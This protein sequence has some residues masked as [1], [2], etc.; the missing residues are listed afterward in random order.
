MNNLKNRNFVC[1]DTHGK[2]DM[3]K[4][5]KWY[6]KE[7]SSLTKRDNL[8]ILGDWGAI[9]HYRSDKHKYKKDVELQVKWAKKNFQ[10]IVIPGNHENYD[11]INKLPVIEKWGGKVKV[12]TP[13]SPYTD[14]DY[15]EIYI[16][17]RGEIYTIN[18]DK[19]LAMGGARSQ[20]QAMRIVGEDYWAEE[21]WSMEEENNCLTNLDKHNWEVDYVFAHTC[22]ERIGSF[23]LDGVDAA[24]NQKTYYNYSAKVKDPLSKFFT[25][26]INEGLKFKEWHFGHWHEDL[27]F[28][29]LVNEDGNGAYYVH[30]L[31]EPYEIKD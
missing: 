6:Q 1:G 3:K 20:D 28:N 19:I 21:L 27:V 22:P 8:F 2:I 23:I 30:Y 10:T 12:L 31:K 26:L 14:K 15:G 11:L 16:L 9:W 24:H 29:Q 18:G 7:F 4:I 25:H 13:K 17:E 5:T